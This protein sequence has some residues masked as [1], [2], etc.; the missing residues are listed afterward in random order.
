MA[1]VGTSSLALQVGQ[2]VRHAF[3]DGRL[4]VDPRQQP[5]AAALDTA[6]RTL[7]VAGP[8]IPPGLDGRSA[9]YRSVLDGRRVLV[10]L[11]HARTAA[12]VRRLLPASEG[13][14]VL[15]TS[16]RRMIDLA[17]ARLMELDVMSPEEALGLF[18]R[19]VGETRVAP[20]RDAA[21][22]VVAACGRSFGR[23]IWRWLPSSHAATPAW[24]RSRRVPSGC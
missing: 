4:Y 5:P 12:E 1:G 19:I 17:G 21:R 20:E 10:L 7:G 9:L 3:P 15:V 13:C 16:H 8:D 14:G 6:L 2:A 24:R 18:T 11:D 22:F 23:V